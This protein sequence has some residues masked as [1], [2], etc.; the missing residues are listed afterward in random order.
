LVIDK[1]SFR[2]FRDLSYPRD[3][4]SKVG[5]YPQQQLMRLPVPV[6]IK[7]MVFVHSFIEYKEKNARSDSA[8]KV[9]FFD[10]SATIDNVTN[11]KSAISRNNRCVVFFKS[12]FLNKAPAHAK[13]VML[14]KDP[15]GKFSIE[16][17]IGKID[18]VSLNP[19]TQ[20]MGLARMEKGNIDKLHFNFSCSDSS[21]EGKLEMLYS[22]L[23]ISLLKMDKEENKY[24][25][26]GLASLAANIILKGSNPGGDGKTR[27]ED[28]H[29]RRLLNRSMFNLIW[30]AIFMGMK[31][32]AGVK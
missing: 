1:S 2:I 3:T 12:K 17:N 32:T 18:V 19:L 11:M 29:F 8:G 23:K 16:G 27:V 28:V 25:K 30:K 13:L 31:Q 7:K 22:G 14:L 5:K 4:I 26:K 6:L 10:V 9:Q 21:S 15:Q 20:P 24:D